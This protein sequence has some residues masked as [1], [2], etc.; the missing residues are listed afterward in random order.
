MFRRVFYFILTNIA[1]MFVLSLAL[2]LTGANRL[3]V[4][5]GLDYYSLIVSSIIIGFGGAFISLMLSKWTAKRATGAYVIKKPSNDTERW[6]YETVKRQALKANIGMPEIA[7]YPAPE[8]NAFATGMF[9]NNALVAVS[10]GLLSSMT[11][12][13]AEGVLAHEISHISNGDM[14]T[15]TLIQGVLNTFVVVLSKI[16]GFFVDRIVFKVER[17]VGPAYY[18]VS[19]LSQVV[20]G[21]GASIIVSWF[22]RQREYRADYGSSQL[23]SKEKMIAALERLKSEYQPSTLPKTVNAFGIN[24]SKSFLKLFAT[25]PA[26]DD[27]IAYLNK[28]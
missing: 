24:S 15:L 2:N 3:I 1:V 6:L 11:E 9:K 17:G 5:N 18:I 7:I 25:H 4:N 10:S 21:I 23:S 20:F 8:I 13:E 27:R 26:I 22:S 14:V 16:V 12:D 28:K 19:L